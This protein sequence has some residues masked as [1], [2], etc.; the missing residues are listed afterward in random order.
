MSSIS[1]SIHFSLMCSRVN[2]V[3][4]HRMF[5]HIE[6]FET[7]RMHLKMFDKFFLI[8]QFNLTQ[9]ENHQILLIIAKCRMT[10]SRRRWKDVI[11]G[12][13]RQSRTR[14]RDEAKAVCHTV[15]QEGRRG[16]RRSN[17]S[18][19]NTRLESEDPGHAESL[20]DKRI[21]PSFSFI[22]WRTFRFFLKFSPSVSL[23]PSVRLSTRSCACKRWVASAWTNNSTRVAVVANC[24]VLPQMKLRN[25]ARRLP[26]FLLFVVAE[27][28]YFRLI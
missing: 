6:T 22:L 23:S 12:I 14:K 3:S 28:H 1:I 11:V 2:V 21:V 8:I 10:S 27:D 26:F 9:V 16:W 4:A 15:R 25:A 7:H 20:N 19:D 18:N 17:N 5:R 24:R 13:K